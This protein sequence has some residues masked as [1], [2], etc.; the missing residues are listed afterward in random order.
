[1]RAQ[2]HGFR[3]QSY[4]FIIDIHDGVVLRHELDEAC[5]VLF[6]G[7]RYDEFLAHTTQIHHPKLDP[8]IKLVEDAEEVPVW[9]ERLFTSQIAWRRLAMNVLHLQEKLDLMLSM[10]LID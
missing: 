10:L 5:L 4:R 1:M 2:G 7:K 6:G 8:L 9:C 3:E